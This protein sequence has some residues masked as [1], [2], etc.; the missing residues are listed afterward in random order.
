ATMLGAALGAGW[1]T[2][3]RYQQ[4][5]V[6]AW[7]GHKWL[8]ADDD[9]VSLLY[10]RQGKL[11]RALT[12][13]G[14]AAQNKVQLTDNVEHALPK[15]WQKVVKVLRQN[16]EWQHNPSSSAEYQQ[17][18]TEVIDWLTSDEKMLSN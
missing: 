17:I 14:H 8:C 12:Q 4:E 7:Q 11:L 3:R 1:A 18:Q 5:L 2:L 6:A 16:P 13:R 9:T 10:L 15:R